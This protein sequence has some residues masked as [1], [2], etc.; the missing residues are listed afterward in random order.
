VK[1]TKISDGD[2]SWC[3]GL[4][5]IVTPILPPVGIASEQVEDQ[6]TNSK[7]TNYEQYFQYE[8]CR[9]ENTIARRS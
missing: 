7:L 6:Q 1:L 9:E 3:S 8:V 4:G 5:E 2:P